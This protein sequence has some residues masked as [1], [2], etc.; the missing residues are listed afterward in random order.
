M[1]RTMNAPTDLREAKATL[2]ERMRACIRAVTPEHWA[3]ASSA[4]AA[5]IL[6]LTEYRLAR[7]VMLY[8]PTHRELCL[9]P[10][11]EACLRTGRPVCLPRANWISGLLQPAVLGA[12]GEELS[13]PV[14]G[15][16]EPIPAAAAIAPARL[17]LVVVPGVAFDI[18]GG[19]LGRGAGFY[20]RFLAGIRAYAVGVCLDEQVVEHVPM[21]D[22]DTRLHAVVTP[23]RTLVRAE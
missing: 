12:W 3:T 18:H 21:G 14:R 6:D 16:R 23:T 20:D 19:R 1:V 9:R 4:V 2:R 5:R 10:V 15:I 13:E 11:A 7:V 22:A 17:D 8:H